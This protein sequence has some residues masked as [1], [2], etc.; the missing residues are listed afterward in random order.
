MH[1]A[2]ESLSR[3]LLTHQIQRSLFWQVTPQKPGRHTHAPVSLKHVSLFGQC[4]KQ[5]WLQW[6]PHRPSEHGSLQRGPK[7]NEAVST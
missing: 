6:R 7:G 4:L 2:S 3:F 1:T 5:V